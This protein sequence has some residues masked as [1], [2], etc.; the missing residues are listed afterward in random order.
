MRKSDVEIYSDTIN[1][2][3]MRHPDRKYPGALIQGDALFVLCRI[4]DDACNEAKAAGCQNV[5][6]EMNE[7]RNALWERLNHYKQVL[8]ENNIELPFSETNT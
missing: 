3:V 7:L 8:A 4:A 1:F 5:F 6:E 2:A